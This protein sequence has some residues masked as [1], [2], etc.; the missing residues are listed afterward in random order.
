MIKF[1]TIVT[2]LL[3]TCTNA[4]S[5][6]TIF[7]DDFESGSFNSN[8]V[9]RPGASGGVVD[10]I[11]SVNA[12]EVAHLGLF[13]AALGRSTSGSLTTNS[14]DLHLDLSTYTQVELS[15]WLKDTRDDTHDK[16]GIYFSD[17]GGVNFKKVYDFSFGS[18]VG[19][20]GRLPP[21]DIDQ[22]A[23]DN[24]L[25]LTNNF[26]IRFQ[27]HDNNE[28]GNAGLYLDDVLVTSPTP[29]TFENLPFQDGFESGA[30]SSA[31]KWGT[32][33]STTQPGSITPS[34]IVSVLSDIN[35]IEV[36]Q[37]GLY[38]VAMGRRVS[39]GLATN[40]LDL[41]LNMSNH[42]QIELGFYMKDTRDDTHE[43]DGIWFS[44]NGGQIFRKIF[45]LEPGALPN[46]EFQQIVVD[47]DALV[48]DLGLT[49]TEQSVIRFQ[50]YD[51]NEFGNAGIY[52][53]SIVVEGDGISSPQ[54]PVIGGEGTL[55][56]DVDGNGV[57]DALSDG[58]LILR[59]AFGSRG[60][61]LTSGVVASD[62]QRCTNSEIE[63]YIGNL[64]R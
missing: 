63:A 1:V 36:P 56:L 10:V 39:G 46:G 34:G 11:S 60:D 41:H 24:G 27:Q 55:I 14:L 6:T 25:S 8:W 57:I 44:N 62:C 50:Q 54:P 16:D 26:V 2:M 13:G 51:N 47:V 59:Y 3:L 64:S 32:P 45:Q 23:T 17:D 28:F 31:W 40:A 49:L 21:I 53:D 33:V 37:Q 38:G 20:Y 15:F 29:P 43:Q 48:A 19:V 4:L 35:G 22:L 52:I 18:W 12:V 42:T 5:E 30:F 9:A 7:S 61:S 58:L